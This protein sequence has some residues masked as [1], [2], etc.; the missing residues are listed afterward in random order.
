MI[1]TRFENGVLELKISRPEK[2]NALSRAMYQQLAQALDEMQQNTACNAIIIHGEGDHFTVG[3]DI[4]DFQEKRAAGDSPAVVFLRQLASIEIPVIAAVEGF[5]VGIGTTMLLHCDFVYAGQGARFRMPF[6]ELGLCPE[7]ASS[8]LLERVVG[9]RK[10]RD[11]LM[12]GRFFDCDEALTAGL[13]TAAAPQGQ[14]LDMARTT[15]RHLSRLPG[16]SLRTTKKM[17]AR[18]D[19]AAVQAALDDEV[20]NFAELINSD[21]TQ[22]IFKSFLNK[23]G[24][25]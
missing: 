23:S 21:A 14:A 22:A 13:L 11:W 5:A 18:D 15:A 3:A 17:L 9:P 20:R 6:V 10:A 7:G 24:R 25:R 8:H 4:G 16:I 2:R 1:D 12:S 19:K